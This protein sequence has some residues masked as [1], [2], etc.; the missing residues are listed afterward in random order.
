MKKYSYL[1]CLLFIALTSLPQSTFAEVCDV[2][3]LMP[4]QYKEKSDNVKRLQICL[5]QLGY[6]ISSPTGYYGSQTVGAVKSYYSSWYGKW[7]GLKFGP[8]GV[9]KIG[10]SL[11]TTNNIPSGGFELSRFNSA[12][13]YKQYLENSN[14]N[15]LNGYVG[16]RRGLAVDESFAVP[17]VAP[18]AD[19]ANKIAVERYSDTNVQVV[20]I[21]EP[22]I[23]KND[24]QT[25]FYK[26]YNSFTKC[27]PGAMC[28]TFAPTTERISLI[29]AL[30]VTDLAVSSQINVDGY[31]N[32][33]MLL[34][35]NNLIVLGNK[36]KDYNVTDV[37]NP[38]EK[39]SLELADN[40]RIVSARLFNN[41]VYLV[42]ATYTNSNCPVSIIKNGLSVNCNDIY[43]PRT[44][45]SVDSNYTV[46]VIDI[47]TGTVSNKFSFVG[48]NDSST[49]YMSESGLYVA[50]NYYEDILKYYLDFI[51]GNASDILPASVVS[52]LDTI[53]GY[54]ISNGSK[55]NEFQTELNK[56]YNGLSDD[57]A[58]KVRN[59]FNDRLTTYSKN[60]YRDL[61]KTAI[62]KIS[63][64]NLSVIGTASIPGKLFNQFSMDEYKGNLRV[65][66]TTG[67]G[68]NR[69]GISSGQSISDVYILDAGLNNLSSVQGLGSGER[70]YSVR[71]LGDRGYVVTFK[72]V[73]P[74]YVLDLSD[75]KNPSLKGEL[76][77]PGYSSYLHPVNDNT[78]L[79][80]GEEDNK[81]KISLFDV[82]VPSNPTEISKYNLDD[83]WS[84][85]QSNHHAFLIDKKHE[86]FFIP[87]S[88][89]GY[90]FSY[91]DNKISLVKSLSDYGV[92][93][94]I[95][96][97]DYL[98]MLGEN[99]VTVFNE[100]NWEKVKELE[101]K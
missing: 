51:K 54:D 20:G 101:L 40:S 100:N 37:K 61:E 31:G 32:G 89:G 69:F 8:A 46:M 1:L 92:K 67:S 39:W 60:H 66:T 71:F 82:S 19:S 52:R 59:E 90:I 83:Y 88:Q 99:K 36:I 7:H 10:S 47:S 33:E 15:Y 97:N 81:V 72:Q 80:V 24:G 57:E 35:D 78:V 86:I 62:I 41:K 27:P 26:T 30:P 64:D 12:E 38:V 11:V 44:Q 18:M 42:A 29:N 17:T 48:S 4:V 16:L 68:W 3:S 45:V 43:Y 22:D 55:W 28:A 2:S 65:A 79:G 21:D 25:I 23:A 73:D 75:P 77:I 96:I 95:Y 6:S 58:L 93:R 98:Y 91:K 5:Q 13:E 70:I 74:F 56:Y 63:L 84:E 53:V 50:Y 9:A 49:I 85:I 87:A 14:N 94:A 34:K 76:K